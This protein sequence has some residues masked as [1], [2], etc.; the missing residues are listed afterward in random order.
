LQD[1]RPNLVARKV[2][3]VKQL[4]EPF[5]EALE[6]RLKEEMDKHKKEQQT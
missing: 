3:N 4:T 6:E 1:D 5:I 2:G